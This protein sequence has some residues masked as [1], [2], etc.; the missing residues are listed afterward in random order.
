[1]SDMKMNIDQNLTISKIMDI[2]KIDTTTAN[3]DGVRTA[4]EYYIELAEKMGFE[5]T[6]CA[7]GKVVEV[8]P[9]SSKK[10]NGKPAKLG[11]VVHLDTVPIGED[12]EHNPYGEIDN[13]IIYGR[14]IVDDKGPAV[15]ALQALK[16]QEKNTDQDWLIIC[17]SSEEA[18]W[19]D[20]E[21]YLEEK[22]EKKEELPEFS[23]TI[24]GDGVQNGCRGYLDLKLRFNNQGDNSIISNLSTPEGAA[25]NSV[26]STASAIINGEEIIA[27]GEACHSSIPQ[28][29]DNAI[30]KLARQIKANNLEAYNEYRDFFD[31]I[32]KM[33]EN[34]G[35]SFDAADTLFF[36]RKPS[37]INGQEVGYT[38][39]CPTTCKTENGEIV[40]NLN[41]RLM[42]GTTEKEVKE[43]IEEICKNYNCSAEISELTLPAYVPLNNPSIQR[44]QEAYKEEMGV[45]TKATI[46]GGVG[47]NATL[48]NCV[49][50]GP[51][52]ASMEQQQEG[53][54]TCHTNM[55]NMPIEHL[56]KLGNMIGIVLQKTLPLPEINR[57]NK[58]ISK[59][60]S[61]KSYRKKI[62]ENLKK[63]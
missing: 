27:N 13:G 48:P 50:F 38:S 61:E 49:I 4:Q 5:A 10:E 42:A 63:Y 52:W 11:I 40:V 44:L 51:L 35:E 12:W 41:I 58:K 7:K 29:G 36:Q 21:A 3:F 43:A 47:Y 15:L 22:R 19:T 8:R 18:E 59:I 16:M 55:E 23:I 31:L 39:V 1:M 57:V 37:F 14:G 62:K 9:K 46:A 20:M 30:V 60:Q 54:D 32:A 2:L 56:I 26:P 53:P 25:N 6:L 34:K 24:D 28:N 33:G 45:E 17:G